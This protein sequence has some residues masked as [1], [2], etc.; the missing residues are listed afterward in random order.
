MAYGKIKMGK[1]KPKPLPT[2]GKRKPGD[3][4]VRKQPMPI[5]GKKPGLGINPPK[6]TRG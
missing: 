6:K 2:P 3:V 4:I 5:P 1:T